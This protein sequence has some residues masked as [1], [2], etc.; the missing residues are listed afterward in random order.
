MGWIA[1]PVL[2]LTFAGVTWYTSLLLTDAYR[3]SKDSGTRN[4]TY[5]QAVHT[6][7]GRQ[8]LT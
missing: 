1:G 3:H 6:T 4:R 7:L 2:L 8:S 5:P